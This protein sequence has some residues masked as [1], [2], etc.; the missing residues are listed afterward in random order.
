[1]LDVGV[2][3]TDREICG[4]SG[5]GIGARYQGWTG[6]AI[7]CFENAARSRASRCA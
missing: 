5:R 1:M 6:L 2:C 7:P 3:G 4:D